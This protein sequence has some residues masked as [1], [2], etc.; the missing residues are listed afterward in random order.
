MKR[1][2]IACMFLSVLTACSGVK[3]VVSIVGGA[4]YNVASDAVHAYCSLSEAQREVAQLVIAGKTY[5]SGVCAVVN[6]N[7]SLGTVLAAVPPEQ[8][9]AVL[10]A[11]IQNAVDNGELSADK[12]AKIKA[13]PADTSATKPP[14][15]PACAVP[16]EGARIYG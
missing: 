9:P 6:G 4:V 1:L 15:K 14:E 2:I 13:M 10:D 3:A 11:A 8:A 16:A 7:K 12:A 5:N